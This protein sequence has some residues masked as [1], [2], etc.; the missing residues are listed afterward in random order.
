[1][2]KLVSTARGALGSLLLG[3]VACMALAAGF[4]WSAPAAAAQQVSKE[5]FEKFKPAQD[6]L[7]KRDYATALRAAKEAAAAA[8]NNDEKEYALKVQLSAAFGVQNWADATSAAEQLIGLPGP[9]AAEKNNYRRMMG[10]IAE[11]QRQ[12]DRAIQY[13]QEAMKGGATARDHEL[14]FR[15]Y[16]IRGDCNNALANL[17]KALGG[18]PANET[19]LKARN[20]CLFK[21]NNT[22]ARVATVEEL[23]RR[24]PKKAYFTDYIGILQELK[25][26]E[27]AMLNVFRW[28]FEKDL[29]EREADYLAF[30][31]AALNAGSSAEANRAL[32]RGVKAGV[33]K[34]N[35]PNSRTSR[36]VA[37]TAKIASDDKAKLPQL[38][39]EARAGKNGE[40]DVNVGMAF[41]GNG[42]NAK[43]VEALQRAFQPDRSN[44]LKRPDDANMLLGIVLLET[45]KKAEAAKAFN[46]AK[47]DPRMAKAASLW[48]GA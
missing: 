44:R 21:Q 1:M 4:S 7:Q 29:I 40:A 8:K 15:V 20:S 12:Y 46:A 36:M 26:D 28:G 47:A 13:T 22:T 33:I 23:L 16:A 39:K 19:Q 27:R 2:T 6:A 41:F 30:A 10:Q 17:D 18:K 42:E 31:D 9:S 14:L 43:A 32:Q 45:G 5:F 37:S 11:Q 38:D 3:T 24:F 34:T 25:T 48:L 35:D